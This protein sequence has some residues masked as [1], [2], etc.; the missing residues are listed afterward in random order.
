VE[1]KNEEVHITLGDRYYR[2]RGLYKNSSLE[3]LKINLMVKKEEK[4]F[5]DLLDLYS[6]RQ[7]QAFISAASAELELDEGIIKGDLGKLLFELEGLQQR[8]LEEQNNPSKEEPSYRMTTEEEE[9][10]I[11]FLKRPDLLEEVARHFEV[12][13]IVGEKT[14]C[15]ALWLGGVSRFLQAPLMIMLQSLSGAGKSSLMEALLKMIPEEHKILLSAMTGQ[16]LYYLDGVYNLSHKILAIAEEEGLERVKYAL[17]TLQ[18]EG[19]LTIASTGRDPQTGR[20]V[21]HFYKVKGPAMIIFTTTNAELDEELLNRCLILLLNISREQTR[22]IHQLQRE[23]RTLEGLKREQEI[24]K[25]LK[26]HQ[27]AQRLLK[28]VRVINPYAKQLEFLF[29]KLRTRRD[30]DKYLTMIEALAFAHQYQRPRGTMKEDGKV[31]PHVEVTLQDIE[32]ANELCNEVLGQSLDDMP[33]HTKKLLELIYEMVQKECENQ[34]IDHEHYLFTRRQ[35]RE[36]T[37]WSHSQLKHHL[38][39]LTDLEYLILHRGR[40][41]SQHRYELL[42]KGEGEKKDR[43]M[44]G[45]IDIEELKKRMKNHHYDD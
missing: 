24:A 2:V 17:K 19:V 10:A 6:N 26:L 43:F 13:G 23:K 28:P 5:V 41:R 45:L 42:Y 40:D 11:A 37:G 9:E 3:V 32:I 44:L 15:Q 38:P 4:Y 35:V 20:L 7:R 34:G 22:A 8:H 14:N 29:N 39:R 18:S 30:N 1:V 33:P 25:I 12:C 21:T 27:N 31:V 16:S 36:Y